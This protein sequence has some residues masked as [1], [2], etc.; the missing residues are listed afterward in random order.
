M[1]NT[2]CND[3]FPIVPPRILYVR[4]VAEVC[5]P[6]NHKFLG[7]YRAFCDQWHNLCFIPPTA[8]FLKIE[9][10]VEYN[11]ENAKAKINTIRRLQPQK[12]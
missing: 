12:Q 8:Q 1:T 4:A 3:A 7:D 5:G 10:L 11:I 9:R 2:T 6:L